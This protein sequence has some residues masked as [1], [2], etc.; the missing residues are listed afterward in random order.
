MYTQ[1][2][3]RW[4]RK[5]PRDHPQHSRPHPFHQA[6]FLMNVILRVRLGDAA[7]D[8]PHGGRTDDDNGEQHKKLHEHLSDATILAFNY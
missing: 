2:S 6:T 5:C 7:T 1:N 4:A 8:V 3:H